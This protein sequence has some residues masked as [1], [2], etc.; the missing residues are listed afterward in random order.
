MAV[1]TIVSLAEKEVI[2]RIW[3]A[4]P[5]MEMKLLCFR[6]LTKKLGIGTDTKKM[7]NKD[8]F[9]RKKYMGVWS[10][11]SSVMRVTIRK[12]LIRIVRYTTRKNTPQT[13]C[14]SWVSESPVRMNPVIL[15]RLGIL[16]FSNGLSS[17]MNEQKLIQSQIFTLMY[18]NGS[19]TLHR[20]FLIFDSPHL[21]SP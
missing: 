10:F 12:L 1:R 16:Y 11:R 2:K 3:K 6:L 19:R 8:K 7:S 15:V 13:V 18:K 21:I 4:Q 17:R 14:S 5:G 20:L 9:F